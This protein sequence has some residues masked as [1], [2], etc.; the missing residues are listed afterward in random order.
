MTERA[1][2]LLNLEPECDQA[3]SI[4]TFA[5][6]RGDPKV[7]PIVS[8]G[9]GLKGYP[10]MTMSL[11]VV[12]I[13][14]EPLTSQP[15]DV[16]INQNSHFAGMELADWAGQESKLEV[17][18]LIASDQYWE[19]VTG[20]VYRHANGPTAIHTK[21]GW[22]LTGPVCVEDS[23]KHCTNLVTTHVLQVDTNPD[24]LSDQLRAFWELESLGVQPR[25]PAMHENLENNIEF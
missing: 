4:V 1:R 11:F 19:L 22:V 3:L 7:C 24:P 21:L 17:D 13:I 12:P 23:G 9:I 25:E 18:I 16:C 20:T 15:T 5:S 6:T 8:V 10:S 2:M 14:C